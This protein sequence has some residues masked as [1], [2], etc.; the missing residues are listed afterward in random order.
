[1]QKPVIQCILAAGESRRLGQ[2]K[3]L[4]PCDGKP[5][6]N[7]HID[8]F[9]GPSIVVLGQ[10][11]KELSK[12]LGSCQFVINENWH[13]GQFSSLQKVLRAVKPGYDALILPVDQWPIDQA[14]Y[15][16]LLNS[17]NESFDVIQPQLDNKNGHP[18]LISE[19]F[20]TKLV[21]LDPT[22]NRLDHIIYEVPKHRKLSIKTEDSAVCNDIDTIEDLHLFRE[23]YSE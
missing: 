13:L 16:V 10:S 2:P 9:Q 20:I 3:A 7:S 23:L 12:N 6:I 4:L 18:I 1:M 8:R 15:Q 17:R 22:E 19:D 11:H 21:A 5:L 14:T